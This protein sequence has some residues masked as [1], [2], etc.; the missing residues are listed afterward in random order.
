MSPNA[1]SLPRPDGPERKGKTL[2]G[3]D[4]NNVPIMFELTVRFQASN[5]QFRVSK[6]AGWVAFGVIVVSKLVV[7][8]TKSMGG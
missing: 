7:H 3:Q 2:M 1:F 6:C 4:Q 8:F 5:Y